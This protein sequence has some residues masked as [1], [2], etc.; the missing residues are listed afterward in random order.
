VSHGADTAALDADSRTPADVAYLNNFPR[1]GELV[2][3][4]AGEVEARM[5]QVRFH[6]SLL[7]HFSANKDPN[8]RSDCSDYGTEMGK[9]MVRE[10]W[11][12]G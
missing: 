12:R 5:R 8:H 1:V 9:I 4:K 3:P 2:K 11:L 7:M 6:L 10:S